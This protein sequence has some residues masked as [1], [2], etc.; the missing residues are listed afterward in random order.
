MAE[1]FL[2]NLNI[3]YLNFKTD[4]QIENTPL[5]RDF[6]RARY[7][8][9]TFEQGA[10][11]LKKNPALSRQRHGVSMS[12]LNNMHKAMADFSHAISIDSNNSRA[13]YSRGC[14]CSK[15][16]NI[17]GARRDFSKT[18]KLNPHEAQAYLNR[19]LLD[20]HQGLYQ[21]A[22]QDLQE[23]AKCFC[24][25]G[26]MVAYKRTQALING[27]KN[28]YKT[29]PLRAGFYLIKLLLVKGKHAKSAENPRRRKYSKE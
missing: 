13:Y 14:V 4:Y 15:M 12:M 2:E 3:D 10:D 23:A 24:E 7:Q 6:S 20:Y 11:R 28:G 25:Q 17:K 29:P 9:Y 8:N 21:A 19:G 22:I 1:S 5:P 16:G 27:L 18:L 26:N